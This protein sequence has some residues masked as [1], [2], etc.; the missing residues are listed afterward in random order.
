MFGFVIERGMEGER[1][2]DE[3]SINFSSP[4]LNIQLDRLPVL[5]HLIL[6]EREEQTVGEGLEPRA[7]LRHGLG[8]QCCGS[9]KF[10]YGIHTSD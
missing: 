1:G 3:L 6:G 7:L 2:G 8:L 5:I 10:W 9:M 4:H